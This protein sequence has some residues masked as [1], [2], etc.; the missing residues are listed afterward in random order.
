[1]AIFAIVF[2]PYAPPPE[3]AGIAQPKDGVKLGSVEIGI[4]V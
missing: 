4:V 2:P 1:M 3:A